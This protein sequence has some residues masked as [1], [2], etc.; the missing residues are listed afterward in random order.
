M[1]LVEQ[2]VQ[3]SSQVVTVGPSFSL[4]LLA[5]SSVYQLLTLRLTF[6]WLYCH[7][8]CKT[9]HVLA[10]RSNKHSYLSTSDYPLPSCRDALFLG[11]RHIHHL[12]ARL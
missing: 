4:N 6:A 1:L 3:F 7:A 9:H 12:A 5:A 11:P 10:Q 8:T 2:V